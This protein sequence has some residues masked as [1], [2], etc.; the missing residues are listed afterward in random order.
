MKQADIA[1]IEYKRN[2][3]L[4]AYQLVSEYK[5]IHSGFLSDDKLPSKWQYAAKL[6]EYQFLPHYWGSPP[7]WRMLLR[8]L[9]GQRT[10]P[11][12]C[13]IGAIKSGT[14]DLAVNIIL[15][16]N[17]IA[18]LAKELYLADPEEWRLFYPTMQQKKQHA[19]RYGLALSPFLAP[20]LHSMELTYRLSQI[21][22]NTK[23]VLTLRDPV[24]RVYS[25]WKWE[26]FLAG[27]KQVNKLPFLASFSEYVDK[28]ITL[29]PEYPMYSAC[30]YDA[31]QTSI[32][33]K[34]V[35]Y[36]IECFGRENVLVLDVDEYF[37][38][39]NQFINKIY[40][41][42]G[43]PNFECP[44]FHNKSNENPLILPPPDEDSL[45]KLRK[46]FQPHNEKLWQLI[47]KRFNW[48]SV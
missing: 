33:W 10:L 28:A 2:K 38:N 37:I 8:K 11:D 18:P 1:A 20:D 17:I 25:H 32:Y 34:A 21:Q 19:A 45:L 39:S 35:S 42:V 24:K 13:V 14:S 12:F 3:L 46:F 48:K 36:W 15:H 29:F 30:G 27:K 6:L 5:S 7:S 40:A 47:D 4:R 16:P 31:L 41:F 44:E 9:N 43:L 23:I 26:I 22:P